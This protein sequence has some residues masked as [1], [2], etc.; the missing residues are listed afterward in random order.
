MGDANDRGNDGLPEAEGSPTAGYDGAGAG[1]GGQIGPYKLLR[2]LG[3]GGCGIVYLAEQQRPV[4]RRV[5][6][7]VIKPGMDTKQVI[8]RFEA[9]RQALALLD[10]PNIAHVFDAG[11]TDTG[12]PYFAMEY[13]KG[14][15]ITEHC[16]RYKL[17]IEERLKLFLTVCEAVQHAHQKAIIHRDIKPSNILVAYEAEQ[18]A[19]MIIDF[20]VAK[21]LTQPLTERTLSQ[22]IDTRTDIYSLGV[23]LYELLTGTLPF[24]PKTLRE[25]GPEQMRRMI[26][27][28]DPQTPSVRL[29]TI[30]RDESLS[31]AQQ[32]RTDI[33]TWGHHL[34]GEL[35]WITL[36]AMDKD[37]TRRYQT[38]HALAEDIQ[39]HLN[40]EPVLAGPPSAVYKLRKFISRNKAF[41]ASVTVIAAVMVLA[42]V[43]SVHQ[44]LVA[45]KARRAESIARRTAEKTQ[46]QAESNLYDALVREA[47]ATRI[48]RRTGYRQE[49]FSAL[50]QA[51]DLG[52]P[53]KDLAELRSEVIA[54]LGDYVGLPP[55]PLM[56]LPEGPNAPVV[57]CGAL[58][59]ADP[60]AAFGLSDGVVILKDL[61]ST[62]DM[63]RFT[64]EHQC[65]GLCFAR[66]GKTLLTLHV[67]ARPPQG[68]QYENAVAHLF[69]RSRDGTW[70]EDK[71]VPV[72]GARV[73]MS[74]VKGFAVAIVDETLHSVRLTDALTGEMVYGGDDPVD[75]NPLPVVDASV[76]GRFVATATVESG[77]SG[78][79][80]VD[81]WDTAL[82]KHVIRLRPNLAR[83]AFLRFS[84][85]GRHLVLLSLSGGVVYSTQTWQPVGLLTEMFGGWPEGMAIFLPDSTV[86]AFSL[87]SRVFLW[88]FVKKERPATLEVPSEN[89]WRLSVSTDGGTLMAHGRK[90]AWLH[91]L[92]VRAER[93]SLVGHSAG[94]PAIAFSPSGSEVASVSKDRSVRVW[95]SATGRLKWEGQLE[96]QGQGISYSADGRWLLAADYERERVYVWSTETAELLSTLGDRSEVGTWSALLT[97]DNRYLVTATASQEGSEGTLKVWSCTI[98]GSVVGKPQFIEEEPRRLEGNACAVVLAPNDRYLAFAKEG[99]AGQQVWQLDLRGSEEARLMG[100]GLPGAV[101]MVDFTPDSQQLVVVDANRSVASYEVQSG[102]KRVW[103]STL[104]THG[105]EEVGVLSGACIYKLSPD[106]TTMAITSSGLG[107]DVWDCKN[108]RLL[109]SLPSREGIIYC[110]A[111]SPDSRRLAVSRSNGD[112]DIWNLGQIERLLFE[113]GLAP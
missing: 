89:A 107:V 20:G 32:R 111:W 30:E 113:L 54:C 15:P 37:R 94:V 22:D 21:A 109:Y 18:A 99:K 93:L 40:Q 63:A 27:E 91:S 53:Q 9:E 29:S 92:D 3:E 24:D 34:H 86:L 68:L 25:G 80:V 66:T 102:Q 77:D 46:Q 95:D 35:D 19:P 39:R 67:P 55:S 108:G 7:K 73:C 90:Q 13:V 48:A 82:D 36:K 26:R 44:A 65:V 23:L 71:P 1:P 58:H 47:R 56:E 43:V 87:G 64:C 106:G 69:V 85:D 81:I 104:R 61:R 101:Q 74:T 57:V 16:D 28:Q 72:P 11:T 84:P 103:F 70:V 112:I 98:D 76:D 100:S 60:I 49:V 42:V 10:H 105:V 96:G 79:S 6:L 14:V 5:A 33:R 31:L 75:V 62:K 83:G 45:R 41:F 88:D 17:T 59:P 51:R 38:A 110:F 4:K 2:I 97:R 50:Q 8:A 78:A 12:R 52:V